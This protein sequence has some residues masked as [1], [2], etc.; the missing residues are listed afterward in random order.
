MVGL[1]HGGGGALI[2]TMIAVRYMYSRSLLGG[3][4][5]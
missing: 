1:L 3:L 2:I 4:L 5:E